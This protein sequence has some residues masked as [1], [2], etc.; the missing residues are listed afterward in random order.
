MAVAEAEEKVKQAQRDMDT[1]L[2]RVQESCFRM[3]QE[4]MRFVSDQPLYDDTAI[5]NGLDRTNDSVND[6]GLL[7]QGLERYIQ[8]TPAQQSVQP[9]QPVQ[10]GMTAKEVADFGQRIDALEQ[11]VLAQQSA[12]PPPENTGDLSD[13]LQRVGGIEQFIRDFPTGSALSPDEG[14]VGIV[15]QQAFTVEAPATNKSSVKAFM[16]EISDRMAALEEGHVEL[17]EKCVAN[18]ELLWE[19]H[20]DFTEK[21][22]TWEQLEQARHP[23]RKRKR[24]MSRAEEQAGDGWEKLESSRQTT[25]SGPGPGSTVTISSDDFTSM[26]STMRDLQTEVTGLRAEVEAMKGGKEQ[27]VAATKRWIA[28]GMTAAKDEIAK[29]TREVGNT[30]RNK[31]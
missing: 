20:T 5:R 31:G 2:G 8:E 13:L 12:P 1:W 11:A 7:L 26:L 16:R 3:I 15:E 23:A 28:T 29:S 22:A 17:E 9:V 21:H 10:E 27:E 14:P 18:E 6:I 25:T 19:Q 24:S 30:S 4:E